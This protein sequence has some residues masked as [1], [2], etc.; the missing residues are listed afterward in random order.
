MEGIHLITNGRLTR[1]EL[2]VIPFLQKNANYIHI[3]EKTKTA[4]EL[5]S[6]LSYL[7]EKEMPKNNH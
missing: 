1:T 7:E 3:R 5:D 4:R 6:I 2:E